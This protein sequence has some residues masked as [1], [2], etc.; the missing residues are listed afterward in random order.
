M[1]YLEGGDGKTYETMI[2]LCGAQD[3]SEGEIFLIKIIEYLVMYNKYE[4]SYY[5]E[6]E[7]TSG[8]FKLIREYRFIKDGKIAEKLFIDTTILFYVWDK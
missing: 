1:V 3:D 2:I 8:D 4:S 5:V 6:P 7:E